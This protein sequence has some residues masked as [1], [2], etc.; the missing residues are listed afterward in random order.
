[1]ALLVLVVQVLRSGPGRDSPEQSVAQCRRCPWARTPCRCVP[2]GAAGLAGIRNRTL[3]EKPMVV[4]RLWLLN[5]W[6]CIWG[7]DLVFFNAN[8]GVETHFLNKSRIL[9]KI[10]Q[11]LH[12][13]RKH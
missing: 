13:E 2:S 8:V 9:I 7:R 3:L 1:M 11:E 4:V 5:H 6:D 12:V 10:F